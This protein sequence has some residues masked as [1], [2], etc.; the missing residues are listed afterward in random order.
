[1]EVMAAMTP[2]DDRPSEDPTGRLAHPDPQLLALLADPTCTDDLPTQVL[3]HVAG[4]AT[5]ADTVAAIARI[6]ALLAGLAGEPMPTD[7]AAR[8]DSALR[9]EAGRPAAAAARAVP[10]PA[11]ARRWRR[12]VTAAAAAAAAGLV[13]AGAVS[14]AIV[15]GGPSPSNYSGASTSSVSGPPTLDGAPPTIG[16]GV[17]YTAATLPVAVHRLLAAVAAGPSA[18]ALSRPA[19]PP[20]PPAGARPQSSAQDSAVP[21]PSAADPLAALR[22]PAALRSCAAHLD[23]VSG[24]RLLAA[25]FAVYNGRPAVVLVLP[26]GTPGRVYVAAVGPSCRADEIYYRASLPRG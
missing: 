16:S 20:L 23:P 1:M 8:L 18:G 24:G 12:P 15:G 17:D 3:D 11:S 13:A 2:R 7:V 10:A 9:A 19:A 26:D 22:A 25:D 4:C 6:P 14:F 21:A 5:C